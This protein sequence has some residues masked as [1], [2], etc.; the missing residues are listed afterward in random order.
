MNPRC[1]SA[2]VRCRIMKIRS[3][4]GRRARPGRHFL[5]QNAG[6]N[7]KICKGGRIMDALKRRGMITG[8]DLPTV[9]SNGPD[10]IGSKDCLKR[11][12][13]F[14]RHDTG[15]YYRRDVRTSC[16]YGTAPQAHPVRRSGCLRKDRL[17]LSSRF[18]TRQFYFSG[19]RF[20]PRHN[21]ARTDMYARQLLNRSI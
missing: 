1:I 12:V 17:R 8:D 9:Q 19:C 3:Q 4:V 7:R 21:D 11:A 16:L 13:L 20:I 15:S 14:D 2:T 6:L 18:L 5:R 10:D